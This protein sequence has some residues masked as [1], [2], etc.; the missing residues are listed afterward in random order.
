M[1]EQHIVLT[2]YSGDPNLG[3]HGVLTDAYAVLGPGFK[4]Q[5]S[6][7]V[8]TVVE[9]YVA[10]T[11]LAG[12]FAEGN[13][14]GLLLPSTTTEHERSGIEDAGIDVLTLEVRHNALGNTVLAND[15]GCLVS[16]HLEDE[17]EKIASFLDVP[18]ETGRIADLSIVGSAAVATN[19]GVLLHR[20]ASEDELAVVEDVLDVTGDIGTV[21][22]GSPFVG[23]GIVANADV[24]LVGNDT[25]GPE[26]ARIEKA[27]GFL[28]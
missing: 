3:M 26:T 17:M 21:N 8:D 16:P 27:L 18:V 10:Q 13:S 19:S 9:S 28:D 23:T 15:H 14:N 22:F 6:L 5:S 4:E 2:D 11:D 7:S 24:A 25:K 12:M 1:P 20:E